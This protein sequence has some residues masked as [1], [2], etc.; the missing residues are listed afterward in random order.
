M[1]EQYNKVIFKATHQSYSGGARKSIRFQLNSK[2]RCLEFDIHNGGKNLFVDFKLGH[3]HPEEEISYEDDNPR[4]V[5]LSDWLDTLIDWSKSNPNHEPITLCIDIKENLVNSS[6]STILKSLNSV[7]QRKLSGKLYTHKDHVNRNDGSL[8]GTNWPTVHELAGK[9]VVFL[10]GDH[11]TKWKYWH[12]LPLKEQFCFVAYSYEDDGGRDY[13]H[14]MLD[15][16]KFAN[17]HLIYWTWGQEQIRKGK[18][19]RI[20]GFDP[21]Y[22]KSGNYRLPTESSFRGLLCN[23]PA[24]DTPYEGWYKAAFSFH[25]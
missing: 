24:T 21:Y 4:S 6:C 1:S 7:L 23:F 10:T 17:C 15:E 9:F 11:Y 12:D 13:S 18:V 14:Q 19:L 5:L 22:D 25:C 2:I 8:T 16:A 20:W 3:N